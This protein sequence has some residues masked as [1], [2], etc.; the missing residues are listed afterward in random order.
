[1]A[2]DSRDADNW[3]S[4]STPSPVLK[5]RRLCDEQGMLPDWI[6]RPGIVK[7]ERRVTTSG[8]AATNDVASVKATR[9]AATAAPKSKPRDANHEDSSSDSYDS[10]LIR[11][12]GVAPLSPSP[13]PP[14]PSDDDAL[15]LNMMKTPCKR[16]SL[17][18]LDS[19]PGPPVKNQKQHFSK[20][21]ARSQVHL[22]LIHPTLCQSTRMI[23]FLDMFRIHLRLMS[24][25]LKPSTMHLKGGFSSGISWHPSSVRGSF[26]THGQLRLWTFRLLH[27]ALSTSFR[28]ESL[29]A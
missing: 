2:G 23:H 26:V 25:Q 14:T 10:C 16:T 18:S 19:P 5:R 20:R 17:T 27:G 28:V 7:W 13:L 24:H 12:D 22:W 1:M 21:R 3:E 29:T 8:E 6:D 11:S 15:N 4:M 9:I